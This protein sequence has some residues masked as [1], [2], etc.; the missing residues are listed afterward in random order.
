MSSLENMAVNYYLTEPQ[1]GVDIFKNKK[2]NLQ[3]FYHSQKRS[4]TTT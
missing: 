1:R 3:P 4:V 2:L